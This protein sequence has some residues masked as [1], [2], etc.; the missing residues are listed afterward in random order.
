MNQFPR[1]YRLSE[2]KLYTAKDF[3]IS[4]SQDF[5]SENPWSRLLIS[6]DED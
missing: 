3:L 6:K 1:L 2:F 5:R 4:A